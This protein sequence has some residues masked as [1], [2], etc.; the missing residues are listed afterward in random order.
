MI[1]PYPSSQRKNNNPNKPMETFMQL[2]QR[3]AIQAETI[4]AYIDQW[5]NGPSG[6]PLHEFLG[7]SLP[8]YKAWVE[9]PHSLQLNFPENLDV[10]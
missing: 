7:M 9:D 3:G 2:F 1:H 6:L 8:M 4:H 10:L 5:H